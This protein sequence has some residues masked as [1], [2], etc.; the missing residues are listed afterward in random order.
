[1]ATRRKFLQNSALTL[2]SLPLLTSTTGCASGPVTTEFPLDSDPDYW[3]KIRD[4][5]PMPRDETYFNASTIG[6]QPQMVVD[7]VIHHMQ[8]YAINIAKTDWKEGGQEL[9]SGYFPYVEIRE[10]LGKLIN[11]GF[12]EISLI[13]NATMGMNYISNGMELESGD[14]IIMT[15]KEHV[16]GKS[17]W[18]VMAKR[19]GVIINQVKIPVPANDQEEIIYRVKKAITTKTRV[20]T[21]PHIISA[22]GLILPVK[23]I[24]SI[25]QEKGILT[26]IDGA[27]AIGHIPIDVRDMGCD[28]YYS[29]PHKWLLAPPGNGML[30]IKKEIAPEIWTTLASGQWDNHEDEGYRLTQRG[31]GNPGLLV[32][33]EAALDF[34]NKIGPEKVTGQI[35]FL[36]DHLREGLKKIDKVEI[37]SSIHPDMCAGVTTYR[38]LGMTGQ[39]LQDAMWETGRLQPRAMG[40]DEGIRH[41]THIFNT[42]QEID[43]SLEIVGEL[44]GAL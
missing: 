35:K 17:G 12:D 14:E 33:L 8:H 40:G 39:E 19:K 11:A 27:Q 30:Y 20:I 5:F 42:V 38:I 32:G 36:G 9:L 31:T 24:C 41:S 43:K 3:G 10:K 7:A 6:A 26:V 15:D 25:A 2:F 13:Q 21:V 22:Y 1:M 29:S 37:R 16:G 34:H 23:E 18:E 44:A 4:L 28:V